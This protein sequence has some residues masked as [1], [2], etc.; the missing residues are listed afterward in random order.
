MTTSST[1]SSS[2]PRSF[3]S[4]K[5]RSAPP[6][7]RARRPD[8]QSAA[9][10]EK[11]EEDG[12]STRSRNATRD[13]PHRKLEGRQ[14][15]QLLGELVISKATSPSS[16]PTSRGSSSTSRRHEGIPERYRETQ[17]HGRSRDVKEKNE[18]LPTLSINSS[19]PSRPI[20]RTSKSST[21]F[22]PRCRKT[23]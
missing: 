13:P 21:V 9:N 2:T 19:C 17:S 16:I 1:S 14:S 23:S 15:P 18:T 22:R 5:G 7:D 12:D 4:S 20:P 6:A 11:P 8:T 3:R 10:P